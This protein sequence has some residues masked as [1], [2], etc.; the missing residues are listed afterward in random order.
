MGRTRMPLSIPSRT[1]RDNTGVS[2]STNISSLTGL[3][4]AIPKDSGS[5]LETVAQ[6][7]RIALRDLSV[8]NCCL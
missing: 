2:V 6:T 3:E 4:L 5:S 7:F 8:F 1:G